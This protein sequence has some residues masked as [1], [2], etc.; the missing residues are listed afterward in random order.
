MMVLRQAGLAVEGTGIALAVG[1]PRSLIDG[2]GARRPLFH[3]RLSPFSIFTGTWAADDQA[4]G[5]IG[6][7]LGADP[8]QNLA[9]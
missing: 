3:G 6:A 7:E 5:W 1:P 4:A 8:A 9:S 2:H